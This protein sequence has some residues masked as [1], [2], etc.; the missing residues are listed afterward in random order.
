MIKYFKSN[1]GEKFFGEQDKG[2]SDLSGKCPVCGLDIAGS[3]AVEVYID[4]CDGR[5]Y[6]RTDE[7]RLLSSDNRRHG[8]LVRRDSSLSQA[9]GYRIPHRDS[10][11]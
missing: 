2:D 7:S 8:G 3:F 1:G 4:R 9:A 10:K 5:L 11:T 6:P